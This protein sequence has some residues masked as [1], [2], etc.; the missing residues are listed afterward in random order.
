MKY[1]H[2]FKIILT[3]LLLSYSL[4]S[5]ASNTIEFTVHHAPGGVSDMLTRLTAKNLPASDYIVQNRPGASGRIA[6]RHVLKG[7]SVLMAT[8]PQIFVTNPLSFKD[9]EYSPKN[10]L[11]IIGVVGIMTNLLVCNS[12]LGITNFRS[13]A[14]TSKSLSF[15]TSGNGSSDHIATEILFR[16]LKGNH[17]IVPYSSGGNK[18]II[19]VLGGST[20]CTFGNYA[21]IKPFIKEERISVLLASHD[22]K[23]GIIT[24]KSYFKEPF[25]YQ[26]HI[27]LVISKKMNLDQK[28]KIIDDVTSAWSHK[29]FKESVSNAG[30]LPILSTDA[31]SINAVLISIQN[32][33]KFTLVTSLIKN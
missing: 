6:M 17:I 15:A 9:L 26:G 11:E 14:N 23:D 33:Y 3:S 28:N 4:T 1:M 32:L 5:T 19:D 10:D 2:F 21:T 30:L 12:K 31:D 22:M 29:E 20:D 13:L 16:H 7:D 24:W 25:P 8:V 27:A 18:S